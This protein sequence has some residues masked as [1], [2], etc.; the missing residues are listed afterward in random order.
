MCPVVVWDFVRDKGCY[1]CL[2]LD[3]GPL[4]YFTSL[5]IDLYI[6]LNCWPPVVSYNLLDSAIDSCVTCDWC[7]IVLSDNPLSKVL[8]PWYQHFLIEK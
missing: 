7:V 8:D 2:S 4:A 5:Y 1:F 6:S 3:F